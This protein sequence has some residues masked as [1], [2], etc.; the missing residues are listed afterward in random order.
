MT[1]VVLQ[2]VLQAHAAEPPAKRPGRA[3][4]IWPDRGSGGA[5][6]G[7]GG[8]GGDEGQ[9]GQS[10]GT[11]GNDLRERFTEPWIFGLGSP[12]LAADIGARGLRVVVDLSQLS[13]ENA[14]AD[15]RRA[16]HFNQ[17]ICLTLRWRDPDEPDY[18]RLHVDDAT[19]DARLEDLMTILVSEEGQALGDRLW[20][21]FYNEISGGPGT[22]LPEHTDQLFD[23]ATRAALRIR[24]EAPDV[25]IVSAALTGF[26]VLGSDPDTR[27]E[28]AWYRFDMLTRAMDWGLQHADAIDMHLHTDSSKTLRDNVRFVREAMA[29]RPGDR[30]FNKSFPLVCFEWSPAKYPNRDDDDAVRTVMRNIWVALNECNI[31]VAAYGNYYVPVE[32]SETFQ[33][34]NITELDGSF[35][36]PIYETYMAIT[37]DPGGMAQRGRKGKGDESSSGAGGETDAVRE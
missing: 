1:A 15:L 32:L 14:I 13:T 24:A 4:V 12:A 8:G 22:I 18:D 21:Q 36:E 23:F 11:R 2:P 19:A 37:R 6:G 16:I 7:G 25:R 28:M 34:K 26:H 30:E 31:Q 9:N 33:W 17:N 35:N 10:D 5:R 27:D 3:R 20:I 29:E